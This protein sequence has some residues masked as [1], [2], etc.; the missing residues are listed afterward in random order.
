MR[1]LEIINREGDHVMI[2]LQRVVIAPEGGKEL[3]L[4]RPGMMRKG[5]SKVGGISWPL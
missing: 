2:A 1:P 3:Y 5:C 4:V